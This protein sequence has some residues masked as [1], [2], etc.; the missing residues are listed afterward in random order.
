[1]NIDHGVS[2][3]VALPELK[4]SKEQSKLLRELNPAG[5]LLNAQHFKS[6]SEAEDILQALE[7]FYFSVQDCLNREQVLVARPLSGE[8]LA[9]PEVLSVLTEKL[10]C[11][12]PSREQLELAARSVAVTGGNFLLG[13]RLDRLMSD[14]TRAQTG[15]KSVAAIL[16]R[17][18]IYF[19]SGVFPLT[20]RPD[21]AEGFPAPVLPGR[22]EDLLESF[23][24]FYE[25]LTVFP[26]VLMMSNVLV[27]QIDKDLPV[28]ASVFF[29]DTLLK[30]EAGFKG[31][32][33]A[34]YYP[35]SLRAT[36]SADTK[37]FFE[38]L[39]SGLNAFIFPDVTNGLSEAVMLKKELSNA[40]KTDEELRQNIDSNQIQMGELLLKLAPPRLDFELLDLIKSGIEESEEE[41]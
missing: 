14:K 4:I 31:V 16:K 13:P 38:A 27:P 40:L 29:H 19:C 26:D 35:K 5:V 37:L 11:K 12:E 3:I 10:I 34:P 20:E 2:F 32:T 1:M 21:I 17:K 18:G 9:L 8:L 15:F 36:Y 23:A 39:R 25:W 28:S 6:F 41:N 33:V 24:Y 30:K 7:Q 22:I